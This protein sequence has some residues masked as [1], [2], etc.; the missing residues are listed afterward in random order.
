VAGPRYLDMVDQWKIM[1]CRL[2]LTSSVAFGGW[3]GTLAGCY[4]IVAYSLWFEKSS[5]VAIKTWM[6]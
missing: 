1:Q 2:G 5:S 3:L 6:L 4:V